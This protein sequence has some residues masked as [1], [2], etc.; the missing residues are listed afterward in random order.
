MHGSATTASGSLANGHALD[1]KDMLRFIVCGSVD[2]GK[3]TLIGR[4]LYET[5]SVPA[6]QLETLAAES[7]RFGTQGNSLDLSLLVDGLSAE[8]EQGITIDVAYRYF[9]TARRK[10]IVIDAPGHEEYTRNMATGASHADVGVLLVDARQGLTEQTRR[11]ARLLKMLGVRRMLLAV[12]K[13]DRVRFLREVFDEVVANFTAFAEE[14]DLDAFEVIPVAALTGANITTL[15][16]AMPWY[17][18]PPLLEFLETVPVEANQA[19]EAA[20]FR[21]PVQLALR[22][23]AGFRGFAGTIASG[24]VAVGDG[25]VVQPSGRTTTV[26]R[27]ASYDGDLDEA[28]AGQAVVL[29]FSDQ[30]DCARGDVI[31]SQEASA[32]SA[33][34]FSADLVWLNEKAFDPRRDYQLKLASRSLAAELSFPESRRPPALND[35]V[36][37]EV[38]AARP[39]IAAPYAEERGLGAF[40]VTDRE[41]QATVAAGMIRDLRAQDTSRSASSTANIVWF[42]S[43]EDG[44]A[45]ELTRVVDALSVS[46]SRV[47]V[48]DDATLRA[49]LCSDLA[50]TGPEWG[51]RALAVA[52]LAARARVTVVVATAAEAPRDA[53]VQTIDSAA[54]IAS[55]WVI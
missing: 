54:D 33:Q 4:L 19:A 26:A 14:A 28:G 17:E 9:S 47:L 3:S 42:R 22:P 18:G 52:R 51:R 5:G 20:P 35:I 40:I 30:V 25:I 34:R 44:K 36:L 8:R 7:R 23:D 37:G 32:A 31:S 10:F 41:S 16:S 1:D 53:P 27:I 24:R 21:M 38:V 2:D 48:I 43:G 55:T 29:V 15:S 46:G 50:E 45:D 13:M 11:H 49:D 6:D 12:N 39:I